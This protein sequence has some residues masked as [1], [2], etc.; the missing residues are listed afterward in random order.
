MTAQ[1]FETAVNKGTIPPLSYL[2]GEET[3]LIERAVRQLLERA[4]DPSLKD[5]NFNVFYGNET[6]GVEILDAAQTL[7]MFA[8]RRA[9]LVK[10]ADALK[11]DVLESLLPYVRNPAATTCLVFTGAKIDQRKKFFQELKKQGCLVEYKRLYDNKLSGFIQSE[12]V[13]QGKTIDPAAAGLLS[14]LIGN[15]LQ[16][17]ASQIEKLAVYCGDRSRITVEDVRVIASS[18]KAFTAFELARFLGMRDLQNALKSLG[19]LFRNGEDAPMMIGA[20]TRHFRQLWRIRELLDRRVSQADIGR[21]LNIHTFFLGEVVQQARNFSRDELGML[22]EEL[23]RCDVASK[24]G[25]GQSAG[26]MHGLVVGICTAT[27]AR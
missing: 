21:E 4:I 8:E 20:L 25:G 15:N 6:K 18:S 10:R 5:F 14:L 17:L 27:L 24:T 1:E 22:F 12:A 23:Y 16:E 3:F 11:A 26:L 2:Y 19:A 9:V 13:V 7:P